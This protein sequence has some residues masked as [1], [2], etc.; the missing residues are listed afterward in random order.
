VL[1]YSNENLYEA[2][3]KISAIKGNARIEKLS[4][5]DIH[6]L[7]RPSETITILLF[8]EKCWHQIR[9]PL[10]SD[11]DPIIMLSISF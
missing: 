4:F 9:S 3:Y 6:I 10:L 2:S 11:P 5:C 1:L 8:L 7:R